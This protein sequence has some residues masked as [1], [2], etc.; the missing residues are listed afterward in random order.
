MLR[1]DNLTKVYGTRIRTVAVDGITF[2]F[3]P[4]RCYAIVGPSGSGKTTLLY[5]LS[6]I[7]TPDR[8]TV[9]FDDVD[10]FSMDEDERARFRARHFGFVFQHF[11]LIPYLNALENVLLRFYLKGSKPDR[12]RAVEV[13]RRLGIDEIK[14]PYEYS[15][16]QQQ[17]I[18][19]ARAIATNPDVL[20]ADEPTGNLDSRNS[21]IVFDILREIASGGKIVVVAT[22]DTELARTC[23]VV[24]RLKDG[25]IASVE[26]G[27]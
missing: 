23:N 9:Y 19:I 20:F 24:I 11:Y 3:E 8:G 10:L 5:L 17:R 26:T 25:R 2:A 21:R 16:G 6:T 22:H 14:K 18:A 4:G 27:G 15:G 1:A 13:L 7:E 12:R